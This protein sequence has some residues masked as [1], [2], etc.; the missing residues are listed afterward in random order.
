MTEQP[1]RHHNNLQ[2]LQS[3]RQEK[4][5]KFLKCY[6]ERVESD[7]EIKLVWQRIIE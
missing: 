5:R 7:K 3:D 2:Q 4:R 1:L 6:F